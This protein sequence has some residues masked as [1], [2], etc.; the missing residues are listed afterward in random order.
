MYVCVCS[1]Q[2][3]ELKSMYVGKKDTHR[4]PVCQFTREQ[5][6]THLSPWVSKINGLHKK[7]ETKDKRQ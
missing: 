3:E 4:L 2:V 1:T 5:G 7:M 6:V